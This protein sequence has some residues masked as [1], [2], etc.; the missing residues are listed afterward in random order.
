MPPAPLALVEWAQD[1]SLALAVGVLLGGIRQWREER[2]A[3]PINASSSNFPTRAHAARAA[4]ETQTQR[5]LRIANA[6]VRTGIR[7]GGLAALFYGAQLVTSIYRDREDF[8]NTMM[9]GVVAGTGLGLLLGEYTASI[10]GA[11]FIFSFFY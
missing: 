9:G 8:Y 5:L 7:F 3:G 4:A 1:T 10:Y 2:S 11:F 6:S